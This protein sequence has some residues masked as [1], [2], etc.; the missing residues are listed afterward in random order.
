M[1]QGL[2]IACIEEVAYHMGYIDRER[3]LAE[4]RRFGKNEYGRYLAAAARRLK[5]TEEPSKGRWND[6][7]RLRLPNLFGRR[8]RRRRRAGP[9]TRNTISSAATTTRALIPVEALVERRDRRY[10]AARGRPRAV[11]SSHGPQGYRG[12]REFVADK[13]ARW[14][15]IDAHGRTTC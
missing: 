10:C 6:R 14:R 8:C 12:L 5:P 11:Q 4:A 1:R 9:A 13:L 2:K 7:D 3:L 15:G